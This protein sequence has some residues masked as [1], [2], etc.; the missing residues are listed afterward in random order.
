M[1]RPTDKQIEDVLAGLAP[2]ED[3]RLV[4]KWF[5]TDEGMAYVAEAF[6]RDARKVR[7]GDEDLYVPH[8]IPSE[9]IWSRIKRQ[10]RRARMRRMMFRAAAVLIPVLLLAGLFYRIDSR[11]DLFGNAGYEEIYVPKGE[12]LQMMFQDGTKVYINSDTRLRY[13]KKFG[14]N[15]REV[16]LSGEAYFKVSSNSNRPFIV[17]LDGPSIRV[18]GTAFDVQNYPDCDKIKVCLDEGRIKMRLRSAEEV[19]VMPGQQVVYDKTYDECHVMTGEDMHYESMWKQNVIAFKDASLPE[20][21]IKLHRWYNVAFEIEDEVPQDLLITLTSD[22][23]ILENVLRDLQKITPLV[24]D[25]D[26]RE[27]RVKVYYRELDN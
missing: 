22:Q 10:I 2:A 11:V 27:K 5:V 1:D 18:I 13:P 6:E 4:A 26:A 3:A 12:R 24:F 16:E 15:S 7:P 23:T 20:V 14:L 19:A 25:Y 8:A 9:E 21:V 17:H